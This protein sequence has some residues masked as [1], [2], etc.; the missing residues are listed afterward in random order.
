MPVRRP[1]CLICLVI[2]LLICAFTGA[3]PP[4]PQWPVDEL[5]ERTIS[6]SGT[7]AD[8]QIKNGSFQVFLKDVAFLKDN[9]RMTADKTDFPDGSKGIIVKSSDIDTAKR[10]VKIGSRI[11]ARGVFMPFEPQRCEGQFDM[12]TYYMVRGYEGS[13]VS[14]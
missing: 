4:K 8:R 5:R 11:E 1:M 7:V 14:R 10:Y 2:L 13:L 12:R 6:I 3:D 9:D